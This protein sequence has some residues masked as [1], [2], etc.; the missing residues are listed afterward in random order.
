MCDPYESTYFSFI[1]PEI[2]P[3]F[4][5][6]CVSYDRTELILVTI[7]RLGIYIFAYYLIT[8]YSKQSIQETLPS[9]IYTYL[10]Y[11]VL[12]MIFIT[13]MSLFVVIIQTP[14]FYDPHDTKENPI[15]KFNF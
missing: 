9:F 13:V 5:T 7:S 2:Y 4:N 6:L 15:F 1:V 14:Y 3:Y 12:A 11:F 8:Q 10:I